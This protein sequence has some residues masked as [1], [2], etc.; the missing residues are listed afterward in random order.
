MPEAHVHLERFNQAKP[1]ASVAV[2]QAG[3]F[4][5][6]TTETGLLVVRFTG[7]DHQSRKITLLVD[8]P[9]TIDLNVRLKTYDYRDDFGEVKIIGDFNDFSFKSARAMDRRSDG[10]YFAEFDTAANR[11][12]YQLLGVKKGSGSI[13][14]TQS[15]D[16][17]YDGEGDYR[18]IV[19]PKNGHAT[20]VFDSRKLLRSEAPEWVRFKD[21]KSSL[22]R[23]VSIYEAM[24]ARR[25]QLHDALVEYKK[26][27]RP[28]NEFSYDWSSALSDL[29]QKIS[30]EQRPLLRQALLFSYLDTG[31]GNYGAKL[32]ETIARKAL[33]EIVPTSPLWSIEPTLI[34]VAIAGAGGP[35]RYTSYVQEVISNHSD[36]AVVKIVR[37]SLSPDR[38]IV[39]GKKAPAFFLA[40]FDQPG[41]IYTSENL[42]GKIVLIDFWATWCVP[43]IEEMPNLHQEYE[44]FKTQG[45]EI[46]SVS[47]DEKPEV[48]NEFRRE[49]WKMPWLH[50]LVASNPDVKKQFEIVGIPRGVM[51]GRDGRIVAT[52]REL[53]G[54]NLDQT[55]T[56]LL[57]APQ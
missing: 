25:D 8:K 27:G 34:G 51:I 43:C 44:K 20:V 32:N 40:A 11:F 2:G 6:V 56:H 4:R 52:D 23:F 41:T 21:V 24:M 22:A 50:S 10:T 54:R 42:K 46:L 7:V 29:A 17:V 3:A 14:G 33:A 28:L 48:V 36:A 16:Y 57:R 38:Q 9:M 53:R 45:F 30:K 19:M 12:A 15:D 35:Q 37:A 1:L 18:S 5:L 26:T 49:K 13:N 31:F 39:V 47:L 55:L